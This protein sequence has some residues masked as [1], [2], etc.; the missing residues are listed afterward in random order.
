MSA[1]HECQVP[2]AW[3]VCTKY[4]EAALPKNEQILSNLQRGKFTGDSTEQFVCEELR[5]AQSRFF[6]NEEQF[7]EEILKNMP[8][9]QLQVAIYSWSVGA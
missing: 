2:E 4:R 8:A 9:M 3:T 6:C 7:A 5:H 1:C